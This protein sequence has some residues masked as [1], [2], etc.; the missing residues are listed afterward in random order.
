MVD[1][2]HCLRSG[3]GR[4]SAAGVEIV[5]CGWQDASGQVERNASAWA[6]DVAHDA[7]S[8]RKVAAAALAAADEIERLNGQ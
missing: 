6:T 4:P 5:V 7:A 8:L 2:Q 1:P 3:L